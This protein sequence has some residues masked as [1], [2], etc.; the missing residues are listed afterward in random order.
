MY[1]HKNF[2]VDFVQ[3]INLQ[4]LL[5][6]GGNRYFIKMIIYALPRQALPKTSALFSKRLLVGS[7]CEILFYANEEARGLFCEIAKIRNEDVCKGIE[8]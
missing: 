6:D 5:L 2:S 8:T 7:G 1:I 3:G 4:L